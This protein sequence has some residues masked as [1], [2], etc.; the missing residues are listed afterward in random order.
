ME[1]VVFIR[2]VFLIRRKEAVIA[3]PVADF[4]ADLLSTFRAIADI[5]CAVFVLIDPGVD[6]AASELDSQEGAYL[7]GRLPFWLVWFRVAGDVQAF[8][9][10][11]GTPLFARLWQLN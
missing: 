11:I 4:Y 8:I 1:S 10:D 9:H 3:A 7:A 5:M 2:I 6:T